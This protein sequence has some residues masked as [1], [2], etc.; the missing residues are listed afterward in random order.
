MSSQTEWDE[1]LKNDFIRCVAKYRLS[2]R[3]YQGG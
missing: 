3:N 2:E 1:Y